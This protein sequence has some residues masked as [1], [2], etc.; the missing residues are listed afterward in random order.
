[1][2]NG[3][4]FFNTSGAG[5]YAIERSLRFNSS[6]SAY[7]S[8]TPASA[9]NRKTWT[10]AGWVKRS[11]LGTRQF[12]F[13]AQNNASLYNTDDFF[14]TS[15][16]KLTFWNNGDTEGTLTTSQVF[17][18]ASAWYH[19]VF[20]YDS[21]QATAANRMKT[22]V[23]GVQITTFSTSTY[24]TQ[25]RDSAINSTRLHQIARRSDNSEGASF[26]GYLAD[27]HF[28]DG[29][30][31]DPTSFGEFDDNGI[32]QPI[33][34]SGSYG[35]NGFHLDF[36][37]NS[38]AAAL[39]TDSAGSNDWTVNNISVTAGA[40]NDSLVDVPINGTEEDTGVGGEVRGNYCTLNPLEKAANATLSN[41]NLDISQ[42][43]GD[44]NTGGT[45][46]ISSGKWYWEFTFVSG[47]EARIGISK[48]QFVKTDT[49]FSTFLG[50]GSNQYSYA[51]DGYKSNNNTNSAT[52]Y[53]A[54]PNGS[55]VSVA[56]DLD[57]G[58]IF[59]ANNG[60]WQQSGDPLA[61]TNAAYTGLSGTFTPAVYTPNATLS[62]NFGQRPFAYTAPS[63][64]KAL[65]TA[66]LP[67]PVITKPSEYM[68]VALYTGNGST[69]TIS[70]LEFSPDL[71]WG[72][73]RSGTA[74]HVWMDVIR[75]T[76]VYLRSDLT[77]AESANANVITSFNSDGFTLGTSSALNGNTDSYAAWCWDAGSST[78]SNTD[79]SIT[80][81]VRANPSAG[82]SIV[83]YTGVGSTG[84]VGHGL[85][86]APSF[87][88]VKART[89]TAANSWR[90]YHASLGATKQ[91]FL[92]DTSAEYTTSSAW[93]DTAPTSAVFS[94][95]SFANESSGN[96]VGYCF[97]PV[98]GYSAMGSYTGSG[99]N[100]GSFIFTGFAVKY[101]LVKC[102]SDA[103]QEWVILD[104][105]RSPYNVTD[106]ALYANAS[107][108]EAS[109][110]TRAVDFLSNGFKFR[111]GSSGA[112][113]FS[114]RTYIYAA[115]AE[116][117]FQYARAR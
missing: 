27:V 56:L 38:T 3:E 15:S 49:P 79:G 24:P 70:G 106:D 109:N 63:G 83:T 45:V 75:G 37:D 72:K 85:G 117:P 84:T 51:S 114:G 48:Q 77:N 5:G 64:F 107:D 113:D 112:T 73:E 22:Y 110:S 33:A 20:A 10:W 99:S 93:N 36:A 68:D 55:I 101:L 108:A 89:T 46:A 17:R 44:Q 90:V 11:G 103:G 58:R 25:N 30:A 81:S 65:N 34:Y 91:L 8:R 29:Q 21:T 16:D 35:T 60:T 4:Q 40:G 97:A 88:I 100:D 47:T 31:L 62:A 42:S 69:Q 102:A 94:V 18:D 104:N 66:N 7:L 61:G 41:G 39:G 98:A 54:Y 43:S 115:F 80:S 28:I 82:F 87:Y 96:Y 9:G 78:V 2:N 26:N 92:E 71:V 13:S 32:W 12:L 76:G 52:G 53:T 116:S 86:V 1:M 50:G 59:F 67:A 105:S 111:N 74:S 57:N 23:N 6:D 95:G 14:F 19:I